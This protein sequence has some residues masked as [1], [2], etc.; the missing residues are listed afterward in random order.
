MILLLQTIM[1]RKHVAL[2][3]PSS[4]GMI[5]DFYISCW[6]MRQIPVASSSPSLTHMGHSYRERVH[7][8]IEICRAPIYG[9]N[10]YANVYHS[11]VITA[12]ASG[13][14]QCILVRVSDPIKRGSVDLPETAHNRPHESLPSIVGPIYRNPCSPVD[15]TQ[16]PVT[17]NLVW[18]HGEH[19]RLV[20]VRWTDAYVQ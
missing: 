19:E 20:V 15:Q 5:T 17:Y 6:S 12:L 11:W 3:L 7:S 13:A 1:W 16:S 18:W 10:K 9:A 14:I 4:R 8:S 2:G